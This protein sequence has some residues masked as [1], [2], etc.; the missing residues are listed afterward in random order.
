MSNKS[1]AKDTE[2]KQYIIQFFNSKNE[3]D[4]IEAKEETMPVDEA[5]ERWNMNRTIL[6]LYEK[7]MQ[8]DQKLR[9]TYAK[10]LIGILIAT[11]ISL[12]VLFVLRGVNVLNY[13]DTAFNIFV[14][15]GIAEVFLLI[16]TIVKYLFKDNL[17]QPLNT[18]LES[19]NRINQ[20]NNKR[21]FL[22]R[23]NTKYN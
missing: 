5:T 4:N 19:S 17:T 1:P 3:I 21:K 12:I 23:D 14:T 15:G 2:E 6:R 18:V 11:L 22:D 16:R 10:I 13:S 7:G 8:E 9:K 20:K